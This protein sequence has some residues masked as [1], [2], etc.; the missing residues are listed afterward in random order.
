M[1]SDQPVNPKLSL[2]AFNFTSDVPLTTRDI[3]PLPRSCFALLLC[4]KPGSGKTNLLLN[5]LCR[6]GE[7]YCGVF[8]R[9]FLISPSQKTM[10][11]DWFESLPEDQRYHEFTEATLDK[12]VQEI[13]D[14][15]EKVLIVLDDCQNDLRANMRALL[16]LLHNRRHITGGNGGSVSVI[17]TAQVMNKVRLIHRPQSQ[18]RRSSSREAS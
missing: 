4:G 15:E 1:W 12:I 9:V 2:A 8:D 3:S 5:L 11:K 7:Y 16:K 18:S 6:K 17:I 10:Q 13:S 14:S